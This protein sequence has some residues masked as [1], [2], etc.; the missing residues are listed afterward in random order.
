[1]S[2]TKCRC[3]NE[4]PRHAGRMAAHR[5][6]TKLLLD[7][8]PDAMATEIKAM[9]R[10]ALRGDLLLLN[11][12]F[13]KRADRRPVD[14]FTIRYQSLGSDLGGFGEGLE[15]GLK[16]VLEMLLAKHPDAG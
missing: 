6:F 3:H 15:K 8:V 14:P 10:R 16:D 5:L 2:Q 4:D 9:I 11:Q 7:R 13:E 12:T 1:M